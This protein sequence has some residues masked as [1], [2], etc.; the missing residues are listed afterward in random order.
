MWASQATDWFGCVRVIA[1]Q[2]LKDLVVQLGSCRNH[3]QGTWGEL[4]A[5]ERSSGTAPTGWSRNL[6]LGIQH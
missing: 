3:P 1:Y 4:K 6:G 5:Y 2:G